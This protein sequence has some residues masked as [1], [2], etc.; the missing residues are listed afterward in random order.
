MIYIK[1]AAANRT[2]FRRKSG[3]KGGQI[4]GNNAIGNSGFRLDAAVQRL[5][6][7]AAGNRTPIGG[8]APRRRRELD[9][10]SA[11]GSTIPESRPT[12][13]WPWIN[14]MT[15]AHHLY[16]RSGGQSRR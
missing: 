1:Q 9:E 5:E 14:G 4:G 11:P 2:K 13:A 8:S 12:L 6:F 3:G 10:K 16:V 15:V 7:E